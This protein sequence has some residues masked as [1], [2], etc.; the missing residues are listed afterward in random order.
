MCYCYYFYKLKIFKVYIYNKN[1]NVLLKE[2]TYFQDNDL[3]INRLKSNMD[4]VQIAVVADH[5]INE[6]I[7][8][9]EEYHHFHN[10]NKHNKKENV[11]YVT[12]HENYKYIFNK[13]HDIFTNKKK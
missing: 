3:I 8:R 12:K 13:N 11:N 4:F 7:E 6:K 5:F 2:I 1:I 10:N 9:K